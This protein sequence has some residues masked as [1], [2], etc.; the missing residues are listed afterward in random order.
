MNVVVEGFLWLQFVV[1]A[2]RIFACSTG[3]DFPGDLSLSDSLS[4][5]PGMLN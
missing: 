1:S 5:V 4:N 3:T 2:V